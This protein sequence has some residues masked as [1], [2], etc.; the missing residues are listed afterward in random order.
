MS[1]TNVIKKWDFRGGSTDENGVKILR[2]G[3]MVET[4]SDDDCESDVT[5]GLIALDATAALFAAHP[6]FPRAVCRKIDPTPHNGPRVWKVVAEYS[7]RPF[8]AA[9]DGGASGASGAGTGTTPATA[10][11]SQ[12]TPANQRPPTVT[13]DDRELI[14]PHTE[15]AI[16]FDANGD[17]VR[18]CNTVGDAFDPPEELPHNFHVITWTFFRSPAQI[19][20][21]ERSLFQDTINSDQVNVLGKVYAKETLRCKRYAVEAVWETG[22]TG[23]ELFF[24]ITVVAEEDPRGYK[25]VTL[26]TGR[27]KLVAGVPVFITDG[28]GE[29]VAEPVPLTAA[30]VPVAVGGQYHYVKTNGY[31]PKAWNGSGGTLYGAG[32]LLG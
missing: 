17:P 16:D 25:V 32:G 15:D 9:G 27:R 21:A 8:A 5:D 26:N 22:A 24:K 30:G 28:N 3:W 10:G 6:R 7:T 1:V 11:A 29:V 18:H 13:V 31:I 23:L 14:L 2:R 4:N 19:Q 12:S 20:W